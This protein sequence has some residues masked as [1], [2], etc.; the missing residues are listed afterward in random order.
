MRQSQKALPFFVAQVYQ[1]IRLEG[2]QAGAWMRVSVNAWTREWVSY[3]YNPLPLDPAL[4]LAHS[5]VCTGSFES[6]ESSER[7][8]HLLYHTLE[9]IHS[10]Y[11]VR[12]RLISGFAEIGGT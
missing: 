4:S 11:G 9:R 2:W 3:H 1:V 7:Y 5:P 8:I 6:A 12:S 10:M